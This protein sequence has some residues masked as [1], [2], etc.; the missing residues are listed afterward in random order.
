MKNRKKICQVNK[1]RA[2]SSSWP[3]LQSGPRA[4]SRVEINE[5]CRQPDSLFEMI[6]GTMEENGGKYLSELMDTE[7]TGFL[8]RSRYERVEGE[9]NHRN[10]SYGQKYMLKGIGEIA[11][12][13][14]RD[15]KRN[16]LPR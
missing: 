11:V 15:R 2:L 4:A 8:G 6:R 5:V 9:S 10:G 3:D 14:P 16:S 13:V 12:T 7:L 1:L